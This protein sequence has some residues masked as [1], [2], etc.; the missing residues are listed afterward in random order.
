MTVAS[1]HVSTV[2]LKAPI[3]GLLV[4]I[5]K[6]PD[7]VFAEKLVGDGISIDPLSETLVAPCDGQ[8]THV[9]PA[10]HA[11][12]MKLRDGLEIMLHVGVDTV[13]LKGEG[14]T[15]KVQAGDTVTAGSE[16]IAFDAD[17]V[18]TH[19]KS[20]LT[21]VVIT[22]ME[23]VARLEPATGKVSVGSDDVLQVLPQVESTDVETAAGQT[24]MSDA[25]LIPNPE[26]LHARPSAVLANL[27]KRYGSEI[28][29]QRDELIGNAKSVT[30]IM[31][32]DIGQHDK[33]VLIATGPDAQEAIDAI[34]PHVASG[35]GDT[36]HVPAP[37]PATVELP[38]RAAPARRRVSDDPD[39]L[40]GVCASPG[41]AVGKVMQVRQETIEVVRDA[42]DPMAER[43]ALTHAVE[44]A[45]A[46]I[47]AVHARLLAEADADKAAIFAAHQELLED[48]ELVHIADSA[49]A[50]GCSAAFAWQQ[51]YE[52]TAEQLE[53]MNNELLAQRANDL[54]DAGRRVLQVLLGI[55]GGPRKYTE[56]CILVAEDL[57]P[58]DTAT[59]DRNMVRG[60]C[61]T[62]GGATSHVSILARSLGIPAVAG[63]DP[64]ALDLPE[65]SQVVLDGSK[66]TLRTAPSAEL[67]ERI[68]RRQET[69]ETRRKAHLSRAHD[70]ATT[71]DG[72]NIEVLANIGGV[73]DAEQIGELG[74]EGVGLLRSEF[75]FMDRVA[76]P[77]EDE[78]AEAYAAIAD[79]IGTDRTIIIRTLDVGGDKPLA[80]LPLPEEDNPFLG[81]RGIRFAL[82]RPEILRTQLRA[83]LRA[84]TRGR[85]RVMFPM[86]ATLSEWRAVKA[87]LDEEAQD[88][89]IRPIPAGIMVEVPSTALQAEAFSREVG[90]FSI[91]TNDL[92]QY[93]LAMD[94]GHPK[95]A[96]QMDALSPAVLA[97]IA[98]TV[99]AAHANGREVGVC[100]G[101]ASDLEAV[102]ILLGIG[103]DELSVSLPAIPGV[104]ALIRSLSAA[105]CKD[106]AAR[107]LTADTA[108]D[109]RAMS[110]S[111]FDDDDEAATT[112]S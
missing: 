22:N 33:V 75:L 112:A 65:G 73:A 38:E 66:G 96:T 25:I 111:P 56:P 21:Q 88:L 101:L 48:P 19:A 12:T 64:A 29:I 42:D 86:I 35:L 71:T 50:K 54:R 55:E 90:F 91:G 87:V 41:L 63:I 59:L 40:L 34:A 53:G 51:A 2:V 79:A 23:R 20:L 95:L 78:Q 27:A 108:A 89:G 105:D 57:A 44:G 43:E 7:P 15:V 98:R 110:P 99:A 61:T 16:M 93:T 4:P 10:G 84:S 9:H 24:V 28:R 76:A 107:A 1:N 103:V 30:G 8:I 39:L 68:R 92:T 106:L 69:A 83:I 74:G 5:E 109:V 82:D 46:Q 18:A 85:V 100:G 52:N 14:F 49:I 58:S 32:M 11:V 37:A 102:P 6:V 3:S 36:G 94:R 26:G 70:P 17:Y 31:K 97:L 45:K 81:E 104:K 13:N 60:F 47:E 67:L 80:Y 72:T 62:L 77:S